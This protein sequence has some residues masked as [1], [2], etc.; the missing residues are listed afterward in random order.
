L[1]VVLVDELNEFVAINPLEIA[2]CERE[3]PGS[4]VEAS[5][6][7][8]EQPLPEGRKKLHENRAHPIRGVCTVHF[9]VEEARGDSG[10]I[11]NFGAC[12][13]GSNSYGQPSLL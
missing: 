3:I 4:L 13:A 12:S 2:L 11:S 5:G 8:Y 6:W 7:Y 10:S 9:M 1:W